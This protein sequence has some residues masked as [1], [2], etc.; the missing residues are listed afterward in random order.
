MRRRAARRAFSELV[1]ALMLMGV[2]MAVG[3]T[4]AVVSMNQMSASQMGIIV[5]LQQQKESAGKLFSLVYSNLSPQSRLV[6]EVYDYGTVS[7]APVSVYIDQTKVTFTLTDPSTGGQIS[8]IPAGG[9]GDITVTSTTY[10]SA[11]GHTVYIVDG[12]GDVVQFST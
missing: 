7:Y 5:A 8:S 10:T 2:V 6:V 12:V 9:R 4:L 11:S 3:G 1:T